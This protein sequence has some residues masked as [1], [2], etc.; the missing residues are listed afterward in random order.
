MEFRYDTYCGLNCGACHFLGAYERGDEEWLKKAAESE[1]CKTDDLRCRGCKTEVT[2]VFCT[3][4]EMRL[5][6]REK[7]VEF[8]NECKDFPCETITNFRNDKHPHHSVIF[9]NLRAI[10]DTGVE[11]WLKEEKQRWSCKTCGTR[12]YWY[13]KTCTNCGEE[14]YNAVKEEKDLEI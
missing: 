6:A 11:A 5:C 12:F 7:G 1:S 4:C 2:A 13:S 14:L 10:S 3:D 8:C 9:K